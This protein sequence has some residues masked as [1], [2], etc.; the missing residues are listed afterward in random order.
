MDN[1]RSSRAG[2]LKSRL[3][4]FLFDSAVGDLRRRVQA[5]R[6]MK[7]W[8]KAGY[9]A[10]P[11]HLVKQQIL[12]AYASDFRT[13]TLI[14]TGTYLGDMVYAM[15]DRFQRIVSIELADCFYRRAKRRFRACPNVEIRRGDS[16]EEIGEALRAI[17]SP[18]LFWLDGHY[19]AGLTA[20][21]ETE[22][23]VIR[24]LQMIFAHSIKNHVILI[25]DARCFDG[26]HDYPTL[27]ELRAL[28]K[29]KTGD[30]DFSV[31]ND[32]VRIHPRCKRPLANV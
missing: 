5:N 26:T 29:E 4:I 18:C 32:V 9:P 20:R 31:K 30:H 13:Q 17:S 15:K 25:D 14:E 7:V 16:G 28:V 2:D 23:P 24:E 21:G 11:P 10:P 22:T 19:S 12:S 1:P 27:G 6:E 3:K 8:E